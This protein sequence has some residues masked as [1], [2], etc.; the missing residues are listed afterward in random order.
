M[1]TNRFNRSN[2]YLKNI[3]D[4]NEEYDLTSNSI[5]DFKFTREMTLY[6]VTDAD[7]AR[8][9]LIAIKAFG[10]KEKMN[11]HWIIMY[12]NQI[13]NVWSD[14]EIGMILNIPHPK[15]LEDLLTYNS[16]VR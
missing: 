8:P 6:T 12:V 13:H 11:T 2:F 7:I 16:N 5:N 3:V 10:E 1:I 15:D 9:D 4:G 14:L